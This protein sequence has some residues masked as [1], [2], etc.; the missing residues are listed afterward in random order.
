MPKPTQVLLIEDNKEYRKVVEL[1]LQEDPDID[2]IEQFGTAEYALRH[3]ENN[4]SQ[5]IDLFLLDLNLPQMSGQEA[6]PLIK[7]RAAGSKIII[8]TQSLK[9]S[10]VLLA[11]QQGADGYLTKSTSVNQLKE[12]I[13]TVM[14][15]GASLD[16]R[17]AHFLANQLKS[18]SPVIQIE[19]NLSGREME[20]LSL[21][22]EGLVKKEIS[23]QLG[24][25][26]STVATYIRRI[27]DKLQVVNAAAA[28]NKAHQLKFFR[29]K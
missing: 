10:D 22:A 1:A 3:L 21:L 2:L 17:I 4:P 11:I 6:L 9:E 24:I 25:S 7:K 16:W 12:A 5:T 29:K 26:Y 20:I 23:D 8:L 28:V 18:E 14:Q 27:Y 13:L 19:K 15:G